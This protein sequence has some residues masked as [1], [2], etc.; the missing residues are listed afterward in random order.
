MT[1]FIVAIIVGMVIFSWIA[2]EAEKH[3]G[4]SAENSAQGAV[5]LGWIIL[6][7]LGLIR[8]FG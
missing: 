2:G 8:L 1:W 6:F 7:V 3:G 5:S 4:A